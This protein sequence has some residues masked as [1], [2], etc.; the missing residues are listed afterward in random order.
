MR[1][2][3]YQAQLRTGGGR[4]VAPF[5]TAQAGTAQSLDHRRQP[6]WRFGV[7]LA[8]LVLE[9]DLVGVDSQGFERLVD[10]RYLVRNAGCQSTS[11]PSSVRL[12]TRASTNSRS[13][14][15]L[16]K[17]SACGRTAASRETATIRHSARRALVR[18]R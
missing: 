2:G 5:R 9:A 11:C 6:Q 7:M 12:S 18:A 10:G 1:P 17:A 8:V 14:S 3:V 16:M 13:D 15:R 4:C